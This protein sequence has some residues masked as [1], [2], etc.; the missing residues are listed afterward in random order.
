MDSCYYICIHLFNVYVFNSTI[1][2]T[3][4]VYLIKFDL[5]GQ[6]LK[7]ARKCLMIGDYHNLTYINRL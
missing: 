7:L 3:E 1:D 6:V 5:V 4:N 2:N